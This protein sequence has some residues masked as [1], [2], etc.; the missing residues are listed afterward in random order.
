MGNTEETRELIGKT[1]RGGAEDV[2]AVRRR[3]RDETEASCTPGP[4]ARRPAQAL[5][6]RF[7]ILPEE[8]VK[9]DAVKPRLPGASPPPAPVTQ[10]SREGSGRTGGV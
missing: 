2:A 7:H 9:V 10:Q 5:S 1:G 8:M 4:R 3:E 6:L